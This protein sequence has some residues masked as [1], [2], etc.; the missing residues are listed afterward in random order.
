[1]RGPVPPR[2]QVY[3]NRPGLVLSVVPRGWVLR[4]LCVCV[5]SRRASDT[6]F[7]LDRQ[8]VVLPQLNDK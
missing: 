1:M 3:T 5:L 8:E 4:T 6:P 2:V 7:I